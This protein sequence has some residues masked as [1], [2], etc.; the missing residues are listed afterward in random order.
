MKI[1][2]PARA[3]RLAPCVDER[4]DFGLEVDLHRN[5]RAEAASKAPARQSIACS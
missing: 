3:R 4:L 2:I 1:T 5:T